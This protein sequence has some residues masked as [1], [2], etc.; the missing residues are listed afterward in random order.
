[1]GL[2][3]SFGDK[4]TDYLPGGYA[5]RTLGS[6]E[7]IRGG[8]QYEGI[9]RG[10]FNLP[11]YDEAQKRYGDYLGGVDARGQSSFRGGQ[12]DLGKLLMDRAQGRGPSV[13]GETL[14][15]Q[16][17]MA[18]RQQLAMAAGANPA[19]AAMAQRLASEGAANASVGLG[20]QAALARATE[21]NQA[22]GLLGN[23]YGQGRQQDIA[24]TAVNDQA[25]AELL[26]QGLMASQMQQQG[27]MNYEQNR[28]QRYGAALGVPTQGEA[29]VKGLSGVLPY[30]L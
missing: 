26:R 28:T 21:A 14:R 3:P 24:N 11:G 30:L 27:G 13:A 6:D 29:L 5:I 25:R 2:F 7:P 15:Q 22:A 23:V 12:E 20:G 4:W 18:Q 16:N 17:E 9:D 1:M 19:N 10:N 8:G